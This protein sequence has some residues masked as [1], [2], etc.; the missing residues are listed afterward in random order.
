MLGLARLCWAIPVI[1][2]RSVSGFRSISSAQGFQ[3]ILHQR[4]VFAF[5]VAKVGLFGQA[6]L[7]KK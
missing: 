7:A 4:A 6:V 5:A 2:R 3:K 1:G